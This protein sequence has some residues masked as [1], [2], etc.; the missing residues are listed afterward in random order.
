M[1]R[2][3]DL[4][5]RIAATLAVVLALDALLVGVVAS[6]LRPWLAPL[7]PGALAP[8]ASGTPGIGWFALVGAVTLALAWAQL[9][10]TRRETLAE[11][12]ARPADAAEYSD[13]HAR[14]SRLAQ[15][16]DLAKPDLA[17]V[18]TDRANCFTVGG[19]RDATVVVS[20]GLLD[21]LD[22]EELDAVLAHELAH[23]KNRD[24]TVLTLATFL[25][26][27]ASDDYS[28]LSLGSARPLLV[29]LAAVVGYGVSTALA[30]VAPFSP[31]SFVAFGG[32]VA[33]TVLFGGVAVGALA[34]PVVYLSARLSRDREFVADRAGALLAGSPAAMA[35]ALE[36]LDAGAPP[37]PAADARVG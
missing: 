22:G 6:L 9:R 36:T 18:E 23:V 32:F 14:L 19:V 37:T 8:T 34:T 1:I 25:P 3:T 7:A 30:G 24:A 4:T 28:V 5:A 15:A 2:D 21:A 13:L 29:G 10:Y 16:A 26:A 12:D 17:V 31:A 35:G 33:F 11:T 27:L 20:T